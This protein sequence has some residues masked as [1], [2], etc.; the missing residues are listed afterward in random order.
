L[1]EYV[2]YNK[3]VLLFDH[4]PEPIEEDTTCRLVGGSTNEIK[5]CGGTADLISVLE[6]LDPGDT[7]ASKQQQ[8]IQ[9]ADDKMRPY[10]LYPHAQT[11]I[12]LQ[13]FVQ[14]LQQEGEEVILLLD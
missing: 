14:E 11:L 12:G 3:A 10:V 2:D 13:Y 1:S 4:T 6:R 7:T 5:P 8:C 9:Y